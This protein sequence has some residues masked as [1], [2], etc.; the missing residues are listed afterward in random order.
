MGAD[1]WLYA[2]GRRY[3]AIFGPGVEVA[4][5]P[6]VAFWVS[7]ADR[8]GDPVLEL[9]C[10]TG[11][12]ALP[13]A[14]AGHRVT[15]LD[16]A[17]AMLQEARRKADAAG[18]CVEWVEA[19]MRAF[20]L[21]RRFAFVFLAHNALCHVLTRADFRAFAGCVRR[22]LAPQGR[23]LVDVFVPNVELLVPRP[24]QRSEF[25]E[26]DDP[27]GGGHVVVT[28]SYVYEPDTQVKR[29]TLHYRLTDGR[30]AT[31]RL[32]LRMFFP[33]E[34]DALLEANGLAVERKWGASDGS[35][36]IATS[37]R[38]LVLCRLAG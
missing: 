38:Q 13:L 35:P 28:H 33:Q 25:A 37:G 21:G 16:N 10:G 4:D 23:F 6:K 7:Q 36:F 8:C 3:D 12:L 32:D 26:Y 17:P 24:G 29:I 30:E 9:A 15:G 18:L 11:A 5:A 14:R 1:C 20:D 19:D 27:D 22:H 2:N 34:L 31:G